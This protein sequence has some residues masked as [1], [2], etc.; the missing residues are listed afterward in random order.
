M[1]Q[2]FELIATLQKLCPTN[3]FTEIGIGDDCAVLTP[4]SNSKLLVTT[5][6]L[7]DGVHFHAHKVSPELI[8]RKALA[9]NLSDIAAMGGT[10]IAAVVSIAINQDRHAPTFVTH[11]Y[12]GLTALAHEY[13][14]AVV[15]GD[16]N[17]WQQPFAINITVLGL[18]HAR[19]IVRRNGAQIGDVICVTGELGGSITGKQFTFLPRLQEAKQLLDDFKIHSMIDISDGLASDLAHIC[20]ASGVNGIL[21][22]YDV[23]VTPAISDQ[24]NALA[25]AMTDGEDFE[26]CFTLPLEE[27]KR[28]IKTQPLGVRV[29]AIGQIVAGQGELF[30]GENDQPQQRIILHGF[31]HNIDN[32][33]GS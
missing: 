5:D 3:R 16:T 14:V 10:P 26:L 32:T 15:G 22:A 17:S 21:H 8:G 1:T 12:E 13:G 33:P 2:E 27:A 9:V 20:R 30:W 24:P 29:T 11:V 25:Q 31:Q 23:P 28:L 6:M 4:T 7:L 18:P 19:G